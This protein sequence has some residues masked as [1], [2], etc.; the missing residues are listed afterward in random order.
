VEP[1]YHIAVALGG[2]RVTLAKWLFEN[3]SSFKYLV[4]CLTFCKINPN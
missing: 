1:L 2:C 4:R 3:R